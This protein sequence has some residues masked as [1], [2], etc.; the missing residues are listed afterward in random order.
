[1]SYRFLS[2]VTNNTTNNTSTSN[3]NTADKL[4]L[5]WVVYILVFLIFTIMEMGLIYYYALRT[6]I[7]ISVDLGLKLFPINTDRLLI[8][9]A[10]ARAALELGKHNI[11]SFYISF[12]K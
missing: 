7:A 10:L 11:L 5:F 2:N 8:I 1:M 6:A 3:V 12:L 4:V 9:S